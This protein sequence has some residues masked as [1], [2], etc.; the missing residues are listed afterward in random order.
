MS[1]FRPRAAA[2]AAAGAALALAVPALAAGS[3]SEKLEDHKIVGPSSAQAGPVTFKVKNTAT[4]LHELVVIKTT[5]KAAKLKLTNGRASEAGSLGEVEVKSGA[6]K[7]LKLTLEPG[8]YVL[9]CNVG[10]HYKAGMFKDFTV[11]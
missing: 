7:T 8:H 11:T 6:S 2:L 4:G 9:L 1:R 3:P 5:V 10:K